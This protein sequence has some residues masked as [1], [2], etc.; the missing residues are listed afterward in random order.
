MAP[1]EGNQTQYGVTSGSNRVESSVKFKTILQRQQRAKARSQN[2]TNRKD[3]AYIVK[4][5]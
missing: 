5:A 2:Q 1:S 4:E 3:M